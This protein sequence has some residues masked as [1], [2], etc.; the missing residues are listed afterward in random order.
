MPIRQQS[1]TDAYRRQ[2]DKKR[3]KNVKR[4]FRNAIIAI[5][6]FTLFLGVDGGSDGGDGEE[7]LKLEVNVKYYDKTVSRC[8][9]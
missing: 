9:Y 4:T 8:V 2:S 3:A 1:Y 6:R 7:H 5:T